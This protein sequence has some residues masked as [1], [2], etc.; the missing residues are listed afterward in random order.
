M[1]LF[2]FILV[3]HGYNSTL[4]KIRSLCLSK[5]P[6][7]GKMLW[8]WHFWN[9]FLVLDREGDRISRLGGPKKKFPRRGF[10]PFIFLWKCA[11]II[12]NW[13][14]LQEFASK[15][16]LQRLILKSRPL[17]LHFLNFRGKAWP[18]YWG[19]HGPTG[20]PSISLTDGHVPDK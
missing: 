4:Q 6:S 3:Q 11:L 14:S 13:A 18:K 19:G 10:F 1:A 2:F 15:P 12:K 8:N 16:C 9:R 7:E 5:C 20:P 17:Q